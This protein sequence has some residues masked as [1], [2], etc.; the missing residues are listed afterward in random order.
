MRRAQPSHVFQERGQD[1]GAHCGRRREAAS[2]GWA[3]S[4]QWRLVIGGVAVSPGGRGHG[5]GADQ[6]PVE[7]AHPGGSLSTD[8][9]G[10]RTGDGRHILEAD[11]VRV[12]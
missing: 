6:T 9:P 2:A 3:L 12:W 11:R 1:A 7:T 8:F 5:A 10:R 4:C